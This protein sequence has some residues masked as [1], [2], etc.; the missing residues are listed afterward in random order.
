MVK[1]S[2]P[3]RQSQVEYWLKAAAKGNSGSN[4]EEANPSPSRT[5]AIMTECGCRY[6]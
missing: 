6:G 3:L 2:G 1:S 5:G 4:S